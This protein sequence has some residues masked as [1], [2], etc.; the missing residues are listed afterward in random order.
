MAPDPPRARTGRVPIGRE[1]ELPWP[2]VS[3]A[4]ILT[5]QSVGQLNITVTG[6]AT[7]FAQHLPTDQRSLQRLDNSRRKHRHTVF[8]A[9]AVAHD[10]LSIFEIDILHTQF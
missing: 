3:C 4:R 6:R 2:I 10:Y 7:A 9:L 8:P 1:H 5:G